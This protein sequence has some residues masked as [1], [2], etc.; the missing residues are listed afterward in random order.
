MAVRFARPT[1]R[2]DVVQGRLGA[3][4]GRTELSC[5]G[6]VGPDRR[7]DHLTRE[8]LVRDRRESIPGDDSEDA[9][10]R[11]PSPKCAGHHLGLQCQV[12]KALRLR[13]A[14]RDI[15]LS[16]RP[17]PE[18]RNVVSARGAL[19]DS[20]HAQRQPIREAPRVLL[21]DLHRKIDLLTH[22]LVRQG[23]SA[24][25]L[26]RGERMPTITQPPGPTAAELL[27]LRRRLGRSPLALLP[28]LWRRY[29]RCVRLRLAGRPVYLISDPAAIAEICTSRSQSFIQGSALGRPRH[30][31]GQGS[32]PSEGDLLRGNRR[33]QES[34]LDH[35]LLPQYATAIARIV[36]RR[37]TGWWHQ[38]RM[39][40][41][42]EMREITLR[43]VSDAI[44]G[45]E[46]GSDPAGIG[47]S[48]NA[49]VS[50]FVRV[51]PS[52]LPLPEWLQASAHRRMVRAAQR[53][54][55]VV[56]AIIAQR[57][58][59][60]VGRSDVIGLWLQTAA[61]SGST[62]DSL[63]RDEV[64]RILLAGHETT[65]NT[66][67]FAWNLL[68]QHPD[69]RQELERELDRV[70]GGRSPGYADLSQLGYLEAVVQETMRLYPP[71]WAVMRQATE[72]VRIGAIEIPAGSEVI[73]SQWIVHRDPG[74]F[75]SPLAFRPERWLDGSTRA[76]PRFAYFPFGAGEC[77]GIG[78]DF[79]FLEARLV[80]GAIASRHRLQV[81]TPFPTLE[82]AL[83]LRPR[84]QVWAQLEDR[85]VAPSDTQD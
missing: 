76:L 84:E 80:L 17:H 16:V 60:G 51:T 47:Q 55:R 58:A 63:L 70:L 53:L 5:L 67:T 3:T 73:L 14:Q 77:P 52:V 56:D 39:N 61:E 19:R 32:R 35:R 13:D 11:E 24:T 79:A 42:K 21:L 62:S 65:A 30:A 29:G 72:S 26:A 74:L 45:A 40:V 23:N 66:L 22:G 37:R 83:T 49:A 38:D 78:R 28:E 75:P 20:D 71:A 43:V 41:G 46:R 27:A 85:R 12:C 4:E 82:A 18:G 8:P 50:Q 54:N 81:I 64:I 33:P 25:I 36:E 59:E 10:N 2:G 1:L 68:S 34:A 31:L 57:R 44:L 48:L 6:R 15:A 9:W 7:I 69:V